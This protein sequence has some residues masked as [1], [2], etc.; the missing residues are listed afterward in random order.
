MT[1]LTRLREDDPDLEITVGG[2]V[3]D[4]DEVLALAKAGADAVL[5]GSAFHDGRLGAGDLL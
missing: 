5:I 2:G 4:R 1:L 3:A